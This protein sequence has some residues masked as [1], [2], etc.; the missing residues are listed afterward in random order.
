MAPSGDGWVNLSELDKCLRTIDPSF[1]VKSYGHSQ[2]HGLL[3]FSGLQL[4][5]DHKRVR[6][7][8]PPLKTVVDNR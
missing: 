6:L 2:L 3:A 1:R 5:A 7:N 8:T 4:T